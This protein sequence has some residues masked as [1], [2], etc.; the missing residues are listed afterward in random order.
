MSAVFIS[1]TGTDVGKTFVTLGLIEH[2]RGQARKVAAL[3]PVLSGFDRETMAQ[4]DSAQLLSALGRPVNEA[5]IAEISPWRFTA[6]LSPDM[7]ARAEGRSLDV[8]AVIDFC[9]R[10]IDAADD[11][12]LIEG[13]GG[14]M[15]PLDTQSTVLDLVTQ[16]ALPIV[17]VAGTYLG[18]LSHVLT[19]RDAARHRGVAIRALV[20]DETADA[21]VPIE[22]TVATLKN[23]CPDVPILVLR[24]GR[25][26][27]NQA[28]FARLADLCFGRRLPETE[29]ISHPAI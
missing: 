24:R 2:V 13:V 19:A 4:S 12:L 7:A 25:T 27:E 9:R 18:T 3:K 15:V 16:L 26:L 8:A 29:R 17:L 6:P 22:E 28:S 1:A 14:L 10:A 23:F 21:T 5:A 20:L 11:V